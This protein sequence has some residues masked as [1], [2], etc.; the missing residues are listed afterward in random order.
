VRNAERLGDFRLPIQNHCGN[1]YSVE[2]R[3]GIGGCEISMMFNRG[4]VDLYQ[5]FF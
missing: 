2:A 4:K 3:P 1:L 5:P